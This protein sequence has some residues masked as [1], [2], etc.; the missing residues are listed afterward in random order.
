MGNVQPSFS[1][2][3]LSDWIVR[4]ASVLHPPLR[5]DSSVAPRLPRFG[6]LVAAVAQL[7]R[8]LLHFLLV[9]C[10]KTFRLLV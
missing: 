4:S 7:L 6:S 2:L 9:G 1:G 5:Y 3:I 8:V 10:F